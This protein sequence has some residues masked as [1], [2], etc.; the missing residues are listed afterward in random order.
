MNL[1]DYLIDQ[2]GK[3]WCRLLA[4]WA[5]LLPASFTVWLVNRFGDV[6]AVCDDGTVC[7]LDIGSGTFVHVAGSREEFM[8]LSNVQEDADDLLMIPF[9][10][11]CVAAGM[12][13]SP[14][15][16]YGYKIPPI[17]GGEYDLENFI[18]I[19][20]AEHYAFHGDLHQQT[21][22]FPDGTRAKLVIT[23]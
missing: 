6:F 5:D 17:L 1:R 16:C 18:R 15:Q 9:V 3:D 8:E 23:R 21:K 12:I 14:N 20:I 19:G 13:L 7:R 10:D 2:E 4:P 22:G 11:Q